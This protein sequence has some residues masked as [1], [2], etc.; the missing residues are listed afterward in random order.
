VWRI[1]GPTKLDPLE[2][3]VLK[4]PFTIAELAGKV[5]EVLFP[6]DSTRRQ[7]NVVPMKPVIRN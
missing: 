7:N 4:K 3:R 6:R 2:Q 5:E 1:G